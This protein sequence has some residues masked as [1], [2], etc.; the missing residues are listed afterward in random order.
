MTATRGRVRLT[1]GRRPRPVA[2][3]HVD[4]AV[5]RDGQ[6]YT[7]HA[8]ATSADPWHGALILTPSVVASLRDRLLPLTEIRTD[9]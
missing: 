7:T 8:F 6:R 5:D 3:G 2:G 4:V 9:D 1:P